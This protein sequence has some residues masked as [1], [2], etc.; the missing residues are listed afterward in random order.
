LRIFL[1]YSTPDLAAAEALRQSLLA[2]RPDLDIY[3]APRHNDAGAYWI[4]R[5]AT[6]L[7][8][9]DAVV[10]VLGQR[11]GPWQELE[12]YE[13]LRQN[14]NEGRPLIAPVLLGDVA[15]GLPFLDQ[16]HRLAASDGLAALVAPL[17]RALHGEGAVEVALP[18]W[19][20]VNPYRGLRA[21][22]TA[23]AAYFFGREALTDDILAR[24]ASDPQRIQTLVGNSGVGK[25]SVAMA[26][27]LAALRARLRPGVADSGWPPALQDSPS[28]PA[29]IMRP[30]PEPVASLAR[31]FVAQWLDSPAEI[32][33]EARRWVDLLMDGSTLAPLIEAMLV[34]IGKRAESDAPSLVVLYVDQG[35]ELYTRADEVQA[36]R[37]STLVA[38]AVR[39]PQL[40]VLMSLRSDHYGSFQADAALF[41][42]ATT[43]DVR[44]L[45]R[46]A[47]EQVVRKP[48]ERLGVR[49]E[50]AGAA[51]HIADA[52]AREP[53][54]MP[55]LSDLL[56]DAWQ[57]MV[58]EAGPAGTLRLPAHLVDIGRPLADK[59]ERFVT[60][61]PG[62]VGELRR[63]FTLRLAVVTRGGEAVR[64]RASRA[65]CSDA[66]WSLVDLLASRDWRLLT[67]G[68]EGGQACAEVAH[69]AL[70]RHWPRAARWIE[71]SREFLI[72]K[73]AF[74][75]EC[76]AWLRADGESRE[77]ALLT[78]LRLDEAE[79]WLAE[80]PADLG[81]EETAFI[82]AS[83]KSADEGRQREA[84]SA[85]RLAR[86][87]RL[88]QHLS[89]MALV[90]V[91]VVALVA[92]WQAGVAREAE[93]L[94]RSQEQRAIEARDEARRQAATADARRLAMAAET[95][96]GS[97]VDGTQLAGLLATAS[98]KRSTTLEG[99][100][101]LRRV[102]SL[103]PAS[104]SPI[105]TPWP[106]AR[107]H[108]GGDGRPVAY[109]RLRGG[110][111][112]T[113]PASSSVALID[114]TTWQ[115]SAFFQHDGR[116]WPVVAPGGRW[117]AMAGYG[118]RLQIV[119]RATGQPALDEHQDDAFDAVFDDGGERLF[120]ARTDGVIEVR[121]APDWQVQTRLAF[122]V[123]ASRLRTVQV[124]FDP[125]GGRLLVH[126][127][128][129]E[130][131]INPWV[132]SLDGGAVAALGEQRSLFATF[133][134]DRVVTVDW[135]GTVTAW[136]ART[137]QQHWADVF[138]HDVL[139]LAVSPDGTALAVALRSGTVRL[140]DVELGR[141]LHAMEHE[142][143]VNAVA[144]SPDGR[145]MASAG[146]DRSAALWSVE[147]GERLVSVP[148]DA[149]VRSLAFDRREGAW[150]TGDMAGVLR[151]VGADG[152]VREQVAVGRPVMVIAVRDGVLALGLQGSEHDQAWLDLQFVDPATGALRAKVEHNGD[153]SAL[154][155]S[156]DGRMLA[157]AT[158][159][160]GEVEL[161]N[162]ETGHATQ[163]PG[164]S[165]GDLFFS[166]DG[167]R[168]LT[169]RFGQEAAIFD[170][171][172][173]QRLA[174]IGELGGVEEVGLAR[175][176]RTLVSFGH[177]GRFRGWDAVTGAQRWS[178]EAGRPNNIGLRLSGDGRRFADRSSDGLKVE[179]GETR[180]GRVLLSVD[181]TRR[182]HFALSA[183]GT[184]IALLHGLASGA[185][186]SELELW[187]IDTGRRVL[188]QRAGQARIEAL[189][190]A[191]F[192]LVT[193]PRS[194]SPGGVRVLDARDG[195]TRWSIDT[196]RAFLGVR[197]VPGSSS[198]V[199]VD[200]DGESQLRQLS[201]GALQAETG[202]DGGRFVADL[203]GL[204]LVAVGRRQGLELR[205]AGGGAV[206]SRLDDP[207]NVRS[208][209]VSASGRQLVIA[210]E[211]VDRTGVWIWR[212]D[213]A[214]PP[215]FIP[216]DDA[217]RAVLP[218]ADPELLVVRGRSGRLGVRRL[219]DWQQM[220]TMS[221]TRTATGMAVAAD[222]ARAVT[223]SG[224]SIRL[225]NAHDGTAL[226]ERAADGA[227]GDLAISP[228]GRRVAYVMRVAAG[229]ES[230]ATTVLAL[231]VPGDGG[232]DVM[233]LP[234]ASPADPRFGPRNES[235]LV[236]QG[237]TA[238]TLIDL[239]TQQSRTVAR[240]LP[241]GSFGDAAFSA[242]GARL[243]VEEIEGAKAQVRVIDVRTGDERMRADGSVAEVPDT[244]R[245]WGLVM[246]D[247]SWRW[248]TTDAN[249]ATPDLMWTAGDDVEPRFD[250]RSA[251]V[252]VP[253]ARGLQPPPAL[254]DSV[255]EVPVIDGAP[256]NAWEVDA[257]N[258][259]LAVVSDAGIAIHAAVD[260]RQLAVW[261]GISLR[262]AGIGIGHHIR[263]IRGLLF[264]DD[265][266]A[267][268]AY[269][270]DASGMQ[271][272]MWLWRWAD[273]AQPQPLID[274]PSINAMAANP[275]RTLFATAEGKSRSRDGE[276]KRMADARVRV[277]DAQTGDVVRSVP[278]ERDVD[279]VAFSPDGALLAARTDR[280]VVVF[281]VDDGEAIR[282]FEFEG[283]RT[284]AGTVAF[285]L[286]G[287]AVVADAAG[288][289]Q[290][291]TL[292]DARAWLLRLESDF[293]RFRLSADGNQLAAF[294]R[295]RLRV[296]DLEAPEAPRFD[297]AP[298]DY[299]DFAFLGA[300]HAL[301]AQ[302]RH[303]FA[304][305]AW[306][307][308]EL[309]TE[310]CRRL[311]RELST[312]EA[313]RY[314]G[315]DARQT[316]C[317]E[318]D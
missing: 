308:S 196:G 263:P 89:A 214:S 131:P 164:V 18:A 209:Q 174:T 83:R 315:A 292:D 235:L 39:T 246:R 113:S 76:Q 72:W 175:D 316:V 199:A 193:L 102:L 248:H 17:L 167:R 53:G 38:D 176:G 276:S 225:W 216:V 171:A 222:S 123:P 47:I 91:S 150:L 101:T 165:A 25:S 50:P 136:D 217:P 157:T 66:E 181:A 117:V 290:L 179:I 298:G 272:G 280:E 1:S 60:R 82:Q 232:G 247:D 138:R 307:A 133:A 309:V 207:G 163:L 200:V 302:S 162:A 241:G 256:L 252:T 61:H 233:T 55:L 168:L 213:E 46:D 306:R 40:S 11:V 221:H 94:A 303:G 194:A 249:T 219:P 317:T 146:D 188:R 260:G 259:R 262:G 268:A 283:D 198:F 120:V 74:E 250:H 149:G 294:S 318:I 153:A 243:M 278:M 275:T 100:R 75:A 297:F 90:A 92:L 191:M 264:V 130:Q 277:W 218:L 261:P 140:I 227:V 9:C 255:L 284:V 253:A 159:M 170:V 5:M 161:W 127:Q 166:S 56:A 180:T 63:L 269:D 220:H 169:S 238:L 85:A 86:Q 310:A 36:R 229:G 223:W 313:A 189:R 93:A 128:T 296:W 152:Q 182:S 107:V 44:P 236:R 97:E 192:A 177:D 242:D 116:V 288:G 77:R 124:V 134:G 301:W 16:F 48:A 204:G 208:V 287:R 32:E 2:P 118:R 240:A 151:V 14:R 190:D 265:G 274:G 139:D 52:A 293:P 186:E 105:A 34:R 64:R 271:G 67:T 257:A 109:S 26:G 15:P 31:A 226:A 184:A 244:F 173:G 234:V 42:S 311:S 104:A 114:T 178:Q 201:D 126:G 108:L 285:A 195:T 95:V 125:R 197:L 112:R 10:L 141:L 57:A 3:F 145:Q 279:D 312:E 183:D 300:H 266:R 314:I 172:N 230:R 212:P 144:F 28:W 58:A 154:R 19:H 143:P 215:R 27:V 142:G 203:P 12:Y 68:E 80:R 305:I 121:R 267:L 79:R 245:P 84:Q 135:Q 231:W 4:P 286:A 155:S 137:G 210:V 147:S 24:L 37:F 211:G 158:V 33:A 273:A 258:G 299:T 115:A 289:V 23:D 69:E 205:E 21:M 270:A 110:P 43:I 59:A 29:V 88:I 71:A 228:D 224:R 111:S 129:G 106:N 160:T 7:Q 122:P 35:E 51:A 239:A 202:P 119:D 81:A 148:H 70:L 6:A 99:Q 49:F 54:A 185:G 96:L 254:R 45:G 8:G 103:L 206:R 13:A 73:T 251:R 87:R 304:R 156:P 281:R 65:E 62:Q 30:G 132:L 22:E 20:L 98:L 282:R 237:Q 187:Q 291:W 78:G 295:E 41:E